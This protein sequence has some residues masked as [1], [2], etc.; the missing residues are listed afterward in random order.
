MK[1]IGKL[2]FALSASLLVAPLFAQDNAELKDTKSRVSYA[3][4]MNL[5][6]QFRNDEVPI[7]PDLLFRGLNDAL[8]NKPTVFNETEMRKVL[9]DYQREHM[10]KRAEK[11]KQ[12]G[13]KN[14]AEGEK[15]LAEN[16]T[17]P[18]VQT[19]PSGL[20]YKILTEGNG[21][22]P[23]SN[24]TVTVNYRGTLI[25][26]TEFDSSYTRGQPATFQV[27]RVVKGWTEA[28]QLMKSGAKW[29]LFIPSELGYGERGSGNKIGPNATLVFEVELISFTA[30]ATPPPTPGT[31]QVVTSDIIKVPSKEEMEKGAKVEVIKKEDADRMIREQQQKKEAEKQ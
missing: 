20:Q 25:D 17:K 16:K 23:K 15:F 31:P 3:I 19:L 27:N 7:D 2:A 6:N 28:L 12:L 1:R 14:R 22:S 9:S 8:Q 21:G 24:D 18:G 29:Q 26:G 5:G 10:A 13:E 30:T 4:G 11:R